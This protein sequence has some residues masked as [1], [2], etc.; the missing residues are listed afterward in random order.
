MMHSYSLMEDELSASSDAEVFD[1]FCAAR[2]LYRLFSEFRERAQ[3]IVG[4]VSTHSGVTTVQDFLRDIDFAYADS[5]I[6]SWR[7]AISDE[8][9][10]RDL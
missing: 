3:E 9:D 6:A 2:D 7:N 1:D 4:K 8:M 5:G 10:R